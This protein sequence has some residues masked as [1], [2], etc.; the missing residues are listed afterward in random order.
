[1]APK[2][3]LL[4]GN[5]EADDKRYDALD[6]K[7]GNHEGK[8]VPESKRRKEGREYRFESVKQDRGSHADAQSRNCEM[9]QKE[10]RRSEKPQ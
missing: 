9:P 10:L 6:R 2:L 4:S 8:V 3:T 5:R 7:E 1:M